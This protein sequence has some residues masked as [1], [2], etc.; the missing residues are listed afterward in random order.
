[1]PPPTPTPPIN[2]YL[3]ILRSTVC[4][5]AQACQLICLGYH[6]YT[7]YSYRRARAASVDPGHLICVF[8][9]CQSPRSCLDTRTINK[10]DCSNFRIIMVKNKDIWRLRSN[11]VY[12]TIYCLIWLWSFWWTEDN[13]EMLKAKIS[14]HIHT[15]WSGSSLSANK[16]IKYY[17][18]YEQR[19]KARMILCT[20]T[21]WIWICAFCACSKTQFRLPQ[22]ILSCYLAAGS[23]QVVWLT[24]SNIFTSNIQNP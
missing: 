24:I 10:L 7:K 12:F 9:V 21:G 2:Y 16:I 19:A 1:M 6:N 11:M 15:V 8:T 22:P 17:R 4:L 23:S 14:K 3:F 18:M 20:C 5:F 13:M